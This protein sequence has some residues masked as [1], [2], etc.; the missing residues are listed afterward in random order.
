MLGLDIGFGDVKA[1]VGSNGDEPPFS[2]KFPAAVC[3]AKNG[4]G[5]L[6]DLAKDRREFLFEGKRYLLG[7][8]AMFGAFSTRSMDFLSRF[9]PLFAFRASQNSGAPVTRLA[10]GLPIAY[11]N[12]ANR[13]ALTKR[14]FAGLK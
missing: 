6:G 8:T 9:A 1:V 13:T 2:F 3:Y 14:L 12:K 5:E 4:V 11:Y 10:V 7:K